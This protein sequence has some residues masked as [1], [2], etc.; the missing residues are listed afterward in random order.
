MGI[1]EQGNNRN[2]YGATSR[3][4]KIGWNVSFDY[5][6]VKHKQAHMKKIYV[7]DAEE[8]D[9]EYDRVVKEFE[10][11]KDKESNAELKWQREFSALSNNAVCSAKKKLNQV[12][13][14]WVTRKGIG[15]GHR[16]WWRLCSSWGSRIRCR[17]W[18]EKRHWIKF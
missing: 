7:I 15:M 5:M 17:S 3:N 6:Q 2:F 8:E 13:W 11:I 14:S 16:K 4:R 10:N 1:E 18:I 12:S 9:Q